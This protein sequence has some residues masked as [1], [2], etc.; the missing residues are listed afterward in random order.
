[1]SLE[2]IIALYG[3][4]AILLGTFFEGETILVMAGF[5]AHQGYL[6]L[7][8]VVL[9]GFLGTLCGDQLYF[10]IGRH[11]GTAFLEKRPYW[12]TRTKRI[13][14]ILERH[15]IL[16]ILGFRFV[17]GMRTVTPF[18]IGASGISPVRF[19][20]LNSVSGL[21]WANVIGYAG[22]LFGHALE[23]LLGKL[24][25]YEL[26]LFIAIAAAGMI[27]WGIHYFLRRKAS[28]RSTS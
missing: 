6:K 2:S 26:L 13:F 9:A 22:Y 11:R 16:L 24:E 12:K 23:L 28:G 7:P 20:I 15:Q 18:V 25:R 1:M 21:L 14:D 27:I 17:Y 5:A 10:Y 4:P 3:Y 8:W 19:F